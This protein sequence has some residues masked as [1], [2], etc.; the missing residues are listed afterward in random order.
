MIVPV[1]E[2]A[3]LIEV[4]GLEKTGVVEVYN[5]EVRT[6]G[7]RYE[8]LAPITHEAM[9]EYVGS[10]GSES[11]P[12]LWELTVAKARYEVSNPLPMSFN[13][14]LIAEDVVEKQEETLQE[15]EK[16]DV[17]LEK[18]DETP[19]HNFEPTFEVD[20]S[21]DAEVLANETIHAKKRGRPST[22]G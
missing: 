13:P 21:E 20:K 17:V 4:F 5:Q 10:D 14:E 1:E 2:R 6:D 9:I 18:V 16:T 11:F 7:F 8:D 19:G 12:R 15:Y 22:K 3:R